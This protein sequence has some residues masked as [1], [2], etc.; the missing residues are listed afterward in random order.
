MCFTAGLAVSKGRIDDSAAAATADLKRPAAVV[1]TDTLLQLLQLP[2]VQQ[3]VVRQQHGASQLQEV[4]TAVLAARNSFAATAAAAA[5]LIPISTADG[6]SNQQLIGGRRDQA[7][8]STAAPAETPDAATTAEPRPTARATQFTASASESHR[9]PN[10]R[11]TALLLAA[12]ARGSMP[13]GSSQQAASLQGLQNQGP[14]AGASHSLQH[15]AAQ[16]S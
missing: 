2:L 5:A 1:Y 4:L 16:S 8:V 13:E 11:L 3:L 9:R 12:A 14:T 15:D 10:P 6:S 7:D